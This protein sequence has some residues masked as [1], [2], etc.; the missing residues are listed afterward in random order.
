MKVTFPD[1][2]TKPELSPYENIPTKLRERK[3]WVLSRSKRPYQLDGSPANVN[4]P[5]TWTTFAQ[6]RFTVE[7][8]GGFD[9]LGFVL[10]AGDPFVVIDLDGCRDPVSGA[11]SNFARQIVER[12]QSFCE[13][14]PSGCGLHIFLLAVIAQEFL[15]VAPTGRKNSSLGI[16][17]YHDRRFMTVTGDVLDA[18][19]CEIIDCQEQLDVLMAECFPPQSAMLWQPEADSD[20]LPAIELTKEQIIERLQT[21]C[22]ELWRGNLDAYDGDQS[23]ADLA[24]CGKIIFYAGDN[25]GLIDEVFCESGL[26]RPKW[27]RPDYQQRTIQRALAWTTDL[28]GGTVDNPDF[29]VVEPIDQGNKRSAGPEIINL[30]DLTNASEPMAHPV[31]DGLLRKGET[32]NLI[33]ATKVGKTFL[34]YVLALSVAMGLKWLQ[35]FTTRQGRV[36]IIDNELHLPTLRTRIQAVAAAMGLQLSD[37][38]DRIDILSLRGRLTDIKS[39]SPIVSSIETDRY[40]LVIIDAWYRMLPP[41]VSEND[42]AGMADLYNTIDKYAASTG[43]A[44]L[45]VHHASKGDQSEKRVT[46]VGSG[47]GSQSRAADTHIVLREHQ[48]EGHVVMSAAVRSFPPREPVVLKWEYPLWHSADHVDPNQL[49]GPG[50]KQQAQR[51]AEGREQILSAIKDTEGATMSDLWKETGIGNDRGERLLAQLKHAGLV[52][53]RPITKRGNECK[54]WVLADVVGEQSTTSATTWGTSSSVP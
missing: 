8:I 50:Q 36:L 39:L 41:G 28:H 17:V 46:D 2:E 4:D 11:L 34:I 22:P 38:V 48:H 42:N 45:L 14:S 23:R 6:A 29:D 33:A 37:F 52:T 16:E 19:H 26:Y 40:S 47:A 27:D 13:V 44:W 9:G 24:F 3:Q 53:S 32:A 30:R 54:L 10:T 1:G 7:C 35:K 25:E 5:E 21:E 51:D 20:F 15:Q 49:S 18:D 12:F 43:S 31:I